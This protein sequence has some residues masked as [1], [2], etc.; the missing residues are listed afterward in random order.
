MTTAKRD[1]LS[2]A[3]RF[4]AILAGHI[5]ALGPN[6]TPAKRAI[7]KSVATL[8]TELEF[9]GRR[10]AHKGT[11]ATV[12]DL[13]HYA[14]ISAALQ[15]LFASI[16][17]GLNINHNVNHNLAVRVKDD[18]AR[19]AIELALTKLILA[20]QERERTSGMVI[21]VT[22]APAAPARVDTEP[23]RERAERETETIRDSRNVVRLRAPET[24]ASANHPKEP[25][26]P[27][28]TELSH[29]VGSDRIGGQAAMT[30]AEFLKQG[31]MNEIASA[32][33]EIIGKTRSEHANQLNRDT[34]IEFFERGAYSAQ[35]ETQNALVQHN[36][37]DGDDNNPATQH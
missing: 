22:P 6:I 20:R 23:E 18:G 31:S 16:G 11:G 30:Y 37:P 4:R 5:D 13:A 12:S 35:R 34:L 2:C 33:I 29:V 36:E 25:R 24:P 7:V 15:Q 27:S 17:L 32:L 9:L 10:F 28:S 19:G 21:D 1:K 26:Q 8:E 3:Q 14:K